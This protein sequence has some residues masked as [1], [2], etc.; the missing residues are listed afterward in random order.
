MKTFNLAI[1]TVALV[2]VTSTASFASPTY[3]G[4]NG[5]QVNTAITQNDSVGA[6]TYA[7]QTVRPASTLSATDALLLKLSTDK[8][9]NRR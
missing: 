2:A 5:N 1:A 9:T 8:D 7:D 6:T 3:G 4:G